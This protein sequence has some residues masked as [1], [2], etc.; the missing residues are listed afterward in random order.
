MI[1]NAFSAGQTA[2]PPAGPAGAHFGPGLRHTIPPRSARRG[3]ARRARATPGLIVNGFH[4]IDGALRAD[5]V[6]LAEIA[7]AAGT[8]C[9]VYSG[10]T[11]TARAAALA[12]AFAPAPHAIHYALKANSTLA[13]LRLL[14]G[15][16]VNA[17]AN[18][19]GEVEV[20]LRAGFI[21]EQIVFT[22]VGKSR[23]E[24]ERAVSLGVKTINAESAGELERI[25]G[26][27]RRQGTRARVALRVNPEVDARTHPN[28]TTGL[29]RNKF[30]VAIDA[31]AAIA[32][33]YA[34][35][36]GLEFVGLHAHIGSQITSLEPLRRA[37]ERLAD[38]TRELRDAGLQLQHLDVG[39][40]LGI[41]YEEGSAVVDV[42]DYG[43]AMIEATRDLGVTLVVEPG[44]WL[45]APAGA[46]L[47]R[48]VDVKT[49][50]G[51]TFVVLDAGMTELLRPAL[52]G[53]YHRIVPLADRAAS[54][55]SCDVVGPVC[56]SSD[57]FGVDRL[58]PAPAVDDLVAV[59]DT[60]AYGA[61]MASNYNR[62]PLPAEVLVEG[63]NWRIVRRRQTVDDMLAGEA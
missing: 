7:D 11:I 23:D 9:Y 42:A 17:D 18:S 29:K 5:G 8:P 52:Y 22:G 41:E 25:D 62:R 2:S 34:S 31:A 45:V 15:L 44:R 16:G 38:L 1:T 26:V 13:V 37:A 49:H 47:A 6:V 61:V 40:G 59:L 21:P 12:T 58:L 57:T 33:E 46:L 32:R 14:R 50:G 19:V 43:R 60:G 51:R 48:V 27:A 4:R 63:S 55:V 39:G 3:P 35:R 54:P 30:G 36:P 53:A 56:E 24:L 28:I 20:A 10:A